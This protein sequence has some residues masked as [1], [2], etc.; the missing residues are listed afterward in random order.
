MIKSLKYQQKAVNDLVAKTID[1]LNSSGSRKR[2]V[3]KAPTGSGKTVMASEMLDRLVTDL[4]D[5]A[6]SRVKECAFIWVAPNKLHEQSY[7]KMQNFFTETRVLQPVMYDELDHSADGYVRPGEILFVNWESI[8]KDKNLMVRETEQQASLYDLCRRTQEHGL[9]IVVII[10]EEH[11]YA[12]KMAKQSEKVLVRINPKVEIRISATPNSM[13]DELVN[14]KREDVIKEEMIKDGIVLNPQIDVKANVA[15]LTQLLLK[16]ALEK[17]QEIAN[18]YKALG[19]NINPLLLIQLPNDN[20]ESLT[21]DEQTIKEEVIFYLEN[22]HGITT[23][24]GK[25]AVWLSGEKENVDDLEQPDNLAEALL[26]KQ[27]IALGWDC[28]RAAVLLIFRKV[29]SFQFSMQTV[30]RILRMPE[31]KHYTN[32]LL[33]KGYVY[34]NLSKDMIEIVQADVN[35]IWRDLR[36][37]RRENLCNIAIASVYT[38]YKSADRN[39]LGP[40]LREFLEAAFNR[41]WLQLP[42]QPMLPGFSPFGDDDDDEEVVEELGELGGAIRINREKAEKQGIKFDVRSVKIEL[43]KDVYFEP[44][45]GNNYIDTRDKKVGYAQSMD[46]LM[47]IFESFCMK[48]IG[49]FEAAHSLKVLTTYLL[50]YMERAFGLFETDAIKVILYHRNKDKFEEVVRLALDNYKRHILGKKRIKR[51][52]SLIEYQWEIPSERYYNSENHD[53]IPQ[54][55][56]H[57]LMPFIRFQDASTP[58]REFE[59]FLEEN[60]E[61]IDWWYK[62]GDNGKQHY[63]IVYQ[64]TEDSKDLFYP[65]Y[66]IRMKNGQIF[67]F[68]TKSRSSDIY[69]VQKHNA[70][71][72]YMASEANKHLNLRGGI[73]IREGNIWKYSQ[74]TIEDTNDLTG[75]T[76]FHPDQYAQ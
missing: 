5:S 74:F 64:Q 76:A 56:D 60:A 13:G 58:E 25:L 31:Q 20:S 50:E 29:D 23:A 9:P 4:R 63:S 33:N 18:A 2:L 47:R 69:G 68:D 12:G 59:Q 46:E 48:L 43:P 19:V 72:K 35:Y 57:A 62:N 65:D 67:L 7:L 14:V 36:A 6:E 38:E 15:S 3:F 54:V 11:M 32:P 39:R 17:R 53:E 51:E 55:K 34:T 26:F 49:G 42:E 22:M 8:N 66:I 30:G 16:H 28:P 21:G 41:L 61:Y 73:I 75:W 70:L 52:R 24:N 10:D 71:I 1:L 45:E 27:A 37:V 40:D 44:E